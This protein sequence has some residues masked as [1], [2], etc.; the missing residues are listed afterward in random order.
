MQ[1][2]ETGRRPINNR[3]WTGKNQTKTK[4]QATRRK[5]NNGQPSSDKLMDKTGRPT[6]DSDKGTNRLTRFG[7]LTNQ[8]SRSDKQRSLASDRTNFF[9]FFF[10]LIGCAHHGLSFSFFFL[11]FQV[12]HKL[13]VNGFW[14]GFNCALCASFASRALASPLFALAPVWLITLSLRTRSFGLLFGE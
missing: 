2:P 13:N 4:Q 1:N 12:S 7:L 10:K 11:W 5:A 9:F 3:Q 14:I 6:W 8:F